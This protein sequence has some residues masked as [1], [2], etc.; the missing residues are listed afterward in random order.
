MDV[1]TSTSL[2]LVTKYQ[3]SAAR[4]CKYGSRGDT[5]T[6]TKYRIRTSGRS[7]NAKIAQVVMLMQL[8]ATVLRNHSNSSGYNWKSEAYRLMM[9][10]ESMKKATSNWIKGQLGME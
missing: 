9:M 6:R 4:C 8:W 3:L 10:L 7:G 5:D 1:Q 2:R